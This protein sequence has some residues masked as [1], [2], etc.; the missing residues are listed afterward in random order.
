MSAAAAHPLPLFRRLPALARHVAWTQ[1]CDL[2]TPVRPLTTLGRELGIESL[3]MKDDGVTDSLLGGNKVRILELVLPAALARSHRLVAIGPTSSNWVRA[4]CSY[5]RQAGASPEAIVF[6]RPAGVSAQRTLAAMQTDATRVTEVRSPLGVPWSLLRTRLRR[7]AQ[8]AV[9]L[10]PGGSSVLGAL[11]YANAACE[12]AEDVA[13]GRCPAPTRVYVA[14]GSGG[15]AAGLAAGF[16]LA[17]LATEVVAVRV[18]DRLLA[19]GFWARRLADKVC[20]Q[21]IT[22]GGAPPQLRPVPIRVLH[23]HFGGGYG[24]PS[25]EG[26]QARNLSSKLEQLTLDPTYSAK[27]MAGLIA[28]ARQEGG[29]Q[30][31]LYWHTLGRAGFQAT[32]LGTVRS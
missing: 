4:V 12:L 27:T 31:W 20:R 19:N 17:G 16:A 8:R 2:P 5:G 18:A 29:G 1:L 22:K 32:D 25:E 10:P 13:A 6:H 26:E 24:T 21:L 15:T 3:W 7:G 30:N 11:A 9:I 28:E 14:L 23:R